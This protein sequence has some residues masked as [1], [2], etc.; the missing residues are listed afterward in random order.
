M[1]CVRIEA[2]Q[3]LEAAVAAGGIVCLGP[4]VHAGPLLLTNSVTLK[5]DAGAVIDAGG[6][7][8]V[9]RIEDDDLVIRVEALTLRGGTA[10]AGGGLALT[11]WSEVTVVGCTLE[12]N[13]ARGRAG[14]S[15]GG[16]GA[17]ASRGTLRVEGT[18]FRG[19]RAP[20]GSDL[21][22]TGTSEVTITGGHLDGD[23]VAREG[24]KL[25]MNGVAVAG[26]LDT[27]GT[28]SRAPTIRV[29]GGT[30]GSVRNDPTLPASV[31]I[32]P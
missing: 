16:G 5:G 28:T 13:Q 24:A 19:N 12:S 15:G 29:Q 10:E 32:V 21:F 8:S 26:A 3:P 4:G 7:D 11:G 14:S 17:Y 2:G 23:V 27:R 31:E 22:V 9:L 25:A 30:L 6:R 20:L 1:D 18:T